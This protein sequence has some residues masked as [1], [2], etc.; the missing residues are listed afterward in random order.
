MSTIAH[1]DL[2]GDALRRAVA[3]RDVDGGDGGPADAHA[4]FDFLIAGRG[5]L[6]GRSLPSSKVQ[7][8]VASCGTGPEIVTPIG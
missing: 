1:C 2:G 5:A 7:T 3:E 6:L 8:Q 4:Q